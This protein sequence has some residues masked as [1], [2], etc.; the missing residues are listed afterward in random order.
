MSQ[1]AL[2]AKVDQLPRIEKVLHE[3][4]DLVNHPE[5]DFDELALKLSMD[6]ILSTKVLRMA[7]SAL[8]GSRREISSIKEAVIRI[9]SD[10][11]RSLVRSSVMSQIFT[12]LDTIS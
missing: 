1:Q 10:S 9:G 4:L 8:F 2:L 11:V 5:F 12:N 6:Q 7:N 3:L